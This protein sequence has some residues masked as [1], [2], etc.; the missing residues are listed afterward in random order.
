MGEPKLRLEGP[1]LAVQT[2]IANGLYTLKTTATLP[3][4]ADHS[5]RRPLNA[6]IFPILVFV[7]ALADR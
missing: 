4:W 3:S 5:G 7:R 2:T 1:G 6:L